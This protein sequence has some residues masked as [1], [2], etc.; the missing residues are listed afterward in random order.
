MTTTSQKSYDKDE[1]DR[2]DRLASQWWD[3][4]G[5]MKPLHAMNSTRLSFIRRHIDDIY[6][7]H[8]HGQRALKKLSILDI[9]CGGGILCKPLAR[10]GAQVT[11]IDLSEDLIKVAK[12]Q[13]EKKDLTINYQC[14]NAED[15]AK[16]KK[17]FDVVTALEVI[18]HVPDP[19]D[20]IKTASDLVKPG[21]LLFI[22]TLNRTPASYLTAI[23]GAEHIMRWLPKGTHQWKKFIKP[24]EVKD[25]I[26]Q[27][28]CTIRDVSG[29]PYNPIKQ[30]FSLHP[31]RLGVNYILC[32]VKK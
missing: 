12:I 4:D 26:D 9:G 16:K 31:H 28:P 23:I 2:F 3:E 25:F 13:A 19:A 30:S 32:A 27:T 21:G 8:Q 11:G 1:I 17:R 10:L 18:E 15:L 20:F 14:V 24:S 7:R 5:P 29:I 22:S 6:N